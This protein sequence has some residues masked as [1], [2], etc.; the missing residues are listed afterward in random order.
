MYR[1]RNNRGRFFRTFL[2]ARFFGTFQ[3]FQGPAR[4]HRRTGKATLGRLVNPPLLV[5]PPVI[6]GQGREGLLREREEKSYGRHESR[7][8]VGNGPRWTLEVAVVDIG[9]Y[10]DLRLPGPAGDRHPKWSRNRTMRGQ[11]LFLVRS[12]SILDELLGELIII[13][14]NEWNEFERK[15]N[16][17]IHVGRPID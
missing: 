3:R 2:A 8:I 4:G 17:E 6:P 12:I 1:V 13:I 9:N 14:V 15:S 10:F 16:E 5:N 7:I 11:I